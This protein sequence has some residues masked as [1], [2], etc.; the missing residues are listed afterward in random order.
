MADQLGLFDPP[1]DEFAFHAVCARC[2]ALL[3]IVP[4]EGGPGARWYAASLWCYLSQV[5]HD[6]QGC[7]TP[8]EPPTPPAGAATG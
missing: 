4:I 3:A 8:F 5:E 2:G 1:P 6:R 7:S